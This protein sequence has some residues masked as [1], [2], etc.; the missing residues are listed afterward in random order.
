VQPPRS[1][2]CRTTTEEV[3]RVLA[4]CEIS[5]SSRTGH[6]VLVADDDT[7]AC[8][9]SC[10]SSATGTPCETPALEPER[11]TTNEVV[12]ELY[13]PGGVRVAVTGFVYR[14]D[15]LIE[16]SAEAEGGFFNQRGVRAA[17]AEIEAERAWRSGWRVAGSFTLQRALGDSGQLLTNSPGTTMG[18]RVAGPLVRNRVSAGV[19]SLYTA[20]RR[21]VHETTIPEYA[22][23]HVTLRSMRS[24]APGLSW[25]VHIDNILDAR[26][27]DPGT[28]DHPVDRLRQDGRTLEA[29]LSWRF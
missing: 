22:V 23:L 18:M 14:I 27:F 1:A 24:I 9:S 13:E 26:Y 5:T 4:T 8:W 12:A 17:G 11:I 2:R 20:R 29:K 7:I 3:E 28:V 15:D 10:C 25:S 6:S 21:T 16:Q 19:E